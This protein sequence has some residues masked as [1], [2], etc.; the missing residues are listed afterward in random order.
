M[1]KDIERYKTNIQAGVLVMNNLTGKRWYADGC[2]VKCDESRIMLTYGELTQ[3]VA[4]NTGILI[5]ERCFLNSGSQPSTLM[6]YKMLK[7]NLERYI[8]SVKTHLEAME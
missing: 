7:H 2:T 5:S 1:S 6:A 3:W 4:F 8:E